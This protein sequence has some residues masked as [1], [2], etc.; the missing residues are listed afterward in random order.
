VTANRE[1]KPL[2][3][4]SGNCEAATTMAFDR[5]LSTLLKDEQLGRRLVPIIP[6]EARTFGLEALFGRY[7]IDA[8]AARFTIQ[9]M[10]AN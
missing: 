1:F 6:D 10:P 3:E 4:G 8:S 7:G 2:L 9:W 5:M